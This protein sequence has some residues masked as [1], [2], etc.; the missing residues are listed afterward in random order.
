MASVCIAAA[1][2]FAQAP[3]APHG[4]H[5]KLAC[6]TCHAGQKTMTAPDQKVCLQCHVSY[7][8]LG[9]KT[10]NLEPNPHDNHMG[11]VNCEDCHKANQAK[12]ELMCNSCHNFTLKEK[13]AKK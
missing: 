9:K 1:P 7:E 3:A 11:K 4:S 6:T 2:A 8:E 13:A 12:P 5:A 10:A